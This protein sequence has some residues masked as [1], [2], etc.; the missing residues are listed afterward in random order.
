MQKAEATTENANINL[1]YLEQ[2]NQQL[3]LCIGNVTCMD[4]F[5]VVLNPTKVN[6]N[7]NNLESKIY[8]TD[9]V[10][11]ELPFP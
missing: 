10:P 4:N 3:Q 6:T 1:Y 9:N 5:L 11:F 2:L 7:T 8:N